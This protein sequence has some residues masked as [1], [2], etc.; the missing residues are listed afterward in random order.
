VHVFA[1]R[2]AP[3]VNTAL[4]LLMVPT[5]CLSLIQPHATLLFWSTSA[6]AHLGLQVRTFFVWHLFGASVESW[7]HGIAAESKSAS[8]RVSFVIWIAKASDLEWLLEL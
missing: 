3:G 5:Y 7:I 8:G 6:A 1:V 2:G 4:Q